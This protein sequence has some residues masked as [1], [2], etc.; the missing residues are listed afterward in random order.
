MAISAQAN[1]CAILS[2][3]PMQQLQDEMLEN[4]FLD[5]EK[6]KPILEVRIQAYSSQC[7]YRTQMLIYFQFAGIQVSSRRHYIE[8]GVPICN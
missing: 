3:K 6:F 4:G 5:E 2:L 7:K 1:Y 8:D